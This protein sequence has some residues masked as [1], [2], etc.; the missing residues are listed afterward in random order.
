MISH[1]VGNKYRITNYKDLA[2]THKKIIDKECVFVKF[3]KKGLAYVQVDSEYYSVP[4]NSLI[5]L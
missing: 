5:E 3:T 4:E 1:T 2:F